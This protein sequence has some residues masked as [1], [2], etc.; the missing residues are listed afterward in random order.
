M[1]VL[2][3]LLLATTLCV[4]AVSAA[5]AQSAMRELSTSQ[6]GKGWA[7]VGRLDL[8]RTGYCTGALIA[9]DLVLTAA[10]CLFDSRSGARFP[11]TEIEF[12]AGWRNGRAEAYRRV[13]RAATHPHFIYNGR[14]R[15]DRVAYDLAVLELDRPIQHP[16]I[17]PFATSTSPRRGD[18]V[19]VVSYATGR[20]EA[21]SIEEVCEVLATDEGVLML[22]CSV[23]FGASGAPIFRIE[24]G[25]ARIVSVVS[26]K[27]R[28]DERPVALAAELEARLQEVRSQLSG[29][30]G[31]FRRAVSTGGAPRSGAKF[32]R[33]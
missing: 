13:R 4:C 9:P 16:S 32:L 23:D 31:V 30:D 1:T 25:E 26:A 10:H 20:D 11:L 18:E 12:R 21:P 5:A 6:S 7:A 15:V 14:D 17:R 3:R 19:G 8:G 24:N 33:P 2:R 22:S 29:S 28:L 27:A